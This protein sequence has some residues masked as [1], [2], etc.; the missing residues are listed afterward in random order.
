M[1]D[2]IL[3]ANNIIPVLMVLMD[4]MK[5]YSNANIIHRELLLVDIDD[6]NNSIGMN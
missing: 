3:Q 5:N 2:R 6:I 1:T 4:G